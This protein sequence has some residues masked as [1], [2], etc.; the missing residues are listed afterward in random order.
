MCVFILEPSGLVIAWRAKTGQVPHCD[1]LWMFDDIFYFF[2]ICHNMTF[3]IEIILKH[4]S[5]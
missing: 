3:L 4:V 2:F 5:I 1:Y